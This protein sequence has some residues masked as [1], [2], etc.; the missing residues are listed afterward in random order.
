[1]AQNT[2]NDFLN[3]TKDTP[4]VDT[5]WGELRSLCSTP[6]DPSLPVEHRAIEAFELIRRFSQGYRLDAW[7]YA[8]EALSSLGVSGE[9]LAATIRYQTAPKTGRTRHFYA[10]RDGYLGQ[11]VCGDDDAGHVRAFYLD[12]GVLYKIDCAYGTAAYC[13]SFA[14][15]DAFGLPGQLRQVRYLH[16]RSRVVHSNPRLEDVKCLVAHQHADFVSNYGKYVTVSNHY[17]NAS[18]DFSTDPSHYWDDYAE[19]H[20]NFLR[21]DYEPFDYD[22]YYD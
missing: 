6:L 4:N 14:E 5:L 7:E 2:L 21:D 3:P 9:L 8:C 12:E 15:A 10:A 1:M 17:E 20:D 19:E 22:D 11:V 18:W 13:C 16:S